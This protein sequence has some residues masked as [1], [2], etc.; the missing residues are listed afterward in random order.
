MGNT[1][2]NMMDWRPVSRGM[3]GGTQTMNP[4]VDPNAW[5]YQINPQYTVPKPVGTYIEND[6]LLNNN[7]GLLV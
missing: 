7:K 6:L 5:I 3:N 1:Y 2:D 4:L